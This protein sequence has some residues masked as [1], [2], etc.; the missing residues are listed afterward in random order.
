M[1]VRL[2]LLF[3]WPSIV[4][5]G[6]LQRNFDLTVLHNNDMHGRFEQTDVNTNTCTNDLIQKNLCFGGFAR[7]AYLIQK[8]REEKDNPVVYLNAGDTFTGTTWFQVFRE[9]ISSDFLNYLKPEAIV[10]MKNNIR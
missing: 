3:V 5:G 7:T 10:S 4:Y 2:L 6:L 9:M 8:F 1:N